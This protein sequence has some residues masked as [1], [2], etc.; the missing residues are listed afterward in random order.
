MTHYKKDFK[1][2]ILRNRDFEILQFLFESKIVTKDQIKLYFFNN[3]ANGTVNRRLR[4]ILSLDLI[5][6]I[7]LEMGQKTIYGYF[8]TPKGLNKVKHLLPYGYG[9][10]NQSDC[11]IHDITLVD[12]RKAFESKK[13]V[14]NYYTENVLQTCHGF[15]DNAQF[16]PFIELNSDGV[17][18][19]DTK[20]G[21]LDLAIEFDATQKNNKRYRHKIND[22]YGKQNIEGV[23]Y[24]CANQCILNA[25]LK[26]DREASHYHQSNPK[27]YFALLDNVIHTKDKMTFRNVNKRI[28]QVC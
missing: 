28:F 18:L 3:A 11:H 10:I 17:I 22:Y 19:I 2:V 1:K 24:I 14:Q 6:R 23:L 9:K 12:I 21:I 8:I 20:I 26:L 27:M 7:P 4:K 16:Q 15:K 5:K 25:L 13:S